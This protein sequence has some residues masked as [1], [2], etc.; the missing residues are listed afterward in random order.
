[1]KGFSIIK[2]FSKEREIERGDKPVD[3]ICAWSLLEEYREV[4]VEMERGI[5][6]LEFVDE[7]TP[8]HTI[9]PLIADGTTQPGERER[10][11]GERREREERGG[12]E[13]WG[14]PGVVVVRGGGGVE[15]SLNGRTTPV[16]HLQHNTKTD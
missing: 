8:P 3:D 2:K 13:R 7:N 12:E 11:D 1:M 10:G 14:V 16:L 6:P 5:H 15:E 4:S 9:V